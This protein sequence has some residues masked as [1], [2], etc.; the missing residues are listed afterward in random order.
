MIN[1]LTAIIGVFVAFM[2]VSNSTTLL[3]FGWGIGYYVVM[4]GAF[5]YLCAIGIKRVN[6]TMMML[7]LIAMLSIL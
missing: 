2:L 3:P 1:R 7:Y 6:V 5:L 4:A